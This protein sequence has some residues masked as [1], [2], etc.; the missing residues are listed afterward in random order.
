MRWRV[1]DCFCHD[2]VFEEAAAAAAA[3]GGGGGGG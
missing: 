3:G 1:S 2:L